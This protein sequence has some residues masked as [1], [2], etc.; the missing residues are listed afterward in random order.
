MK[1]HNKEIELKNQLA[2]QYTTVGTNI[3]QKVGVPDATE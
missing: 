2:H 3:V 1:N